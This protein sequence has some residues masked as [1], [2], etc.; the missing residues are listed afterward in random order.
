MFV[1]Q[2]TDLVG[3][4]KV[5]DSP[6]MMLKGCRILCNSNSCCVSGLIFAYGITGSGKTHTMTGEPSDGGLLPRGLDVLFNSIGG[7]QTKPCV[8]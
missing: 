5:L 2:Q 7:F 8:S 6:Q 4:R 3:V 1:S